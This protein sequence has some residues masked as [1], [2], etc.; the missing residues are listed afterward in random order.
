MV[1]QEQDRTFDLQHF[2]V[3]RPEAIQQANKPSQHSNHRVK[4]IENGAKA[5]ELCSVEV[6]HKLQFSLT[7]SPQHP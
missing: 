3:I 6:P 1:R 5:K 4:E 2:G 7:L